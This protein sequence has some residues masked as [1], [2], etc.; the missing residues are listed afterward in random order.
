MTRGRALD[1]LG[2]GRGTIDRDLEARIGQLTRE[3]GEARAENVRLRSELHS[4]SS[5][6][7]ARTREL[8]QVQEQQGATAELLKVIGRS[9]F[10]LQPVFETLVQNAVRLCAA[11]R[12]LVFRFDRDLLR[13]AVG[14]NVSLDLK[15]YFERHPIAPG[16]N[17]NAG[18]AALERRTVHNIDVRSDPEYT[19]GPAQVD[20]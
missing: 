11:E 13:Y 2:G 14:H 19:Y 9:T 5:E 8:N 18:R 4:K 15:E 16:R 10:D 17:S 20:P 1:P 6:I 3:L 12:G 7:D